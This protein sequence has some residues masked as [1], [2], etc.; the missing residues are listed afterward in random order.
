LH[1]I[2]LAGGKGKRLGAVAADRP[3]SLVDLD[4]DYDVLTV[5]VHQL[6]NCGY[7]RITLC[8]SHLA[9]M[10]MAAL[11]DGR[12]FGISIDYCVDRAAA[13]TA[14]PLRGVADYHEPALVINGDLL[15]AIDY[16]ELHDEHVRR[17]AILTITAVEHAVQVDYGVL[18]V[19][20]G[21]VIGV[22]EKPRISVTVSGGV[23]MASPGVL[24]F[25]GLKP[26][27]NMPDLVAAM[28][29]AGEPVHAYRTAA[30][31]Y[32]IGTP[33]GLERARRAF[34]VNR[35]HFLRPAVPNGDH[36]FGNADRVSRQELPPARIHSS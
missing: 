26:V 34:A 15:T 4:A 36:A 33:S 2:V 13:G 11:G 22:S 28:V 6:R 24:S 30:P 5:V 23:Y 27:I 3:K 12:K 7:S 29:A 8:V 14:G 9:E 18:D 19:C 16:N 32:D 20:G 1:A 17:G 10:I 31:W 25:L 21:R 35:D